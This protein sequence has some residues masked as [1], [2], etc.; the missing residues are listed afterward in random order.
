[1]LVREGVIPTGTAHQ[2][3]IF[4]SAVFIIATSSVEIDFNKSVMLIG[5]NQL[6]EQL[7]RI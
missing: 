4:S 7:F 3:M 5:P 1:M 6:Q 2:Y